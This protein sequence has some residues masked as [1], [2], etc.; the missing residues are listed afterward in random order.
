MTG[1]AGADAMAAILGFAGFLTVGCLCWY[2]SSRP[3]A[4]IRLFVPR[5]ELMPAARR[6]LR[7]GTAYEKGIRIIALIQILIGV[8]FLVWAIVTLLS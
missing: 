5:G 2:F 7:G 6:I 3:R 4:Y 8:G 1:V